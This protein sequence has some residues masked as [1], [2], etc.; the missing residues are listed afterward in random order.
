MA[1][2]AKRTVETKNKDKPAADTKTSPSAIST[3]AA[4]DSR[5]ADAK[6]DDEEKTKEEGTGTFKPVI[7]LV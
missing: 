5:I 1:P 3:S 6:D 7:N 2:T 4:I